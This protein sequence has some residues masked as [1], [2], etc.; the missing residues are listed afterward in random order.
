MSELNEDVVRAF[1]ALD[2]EGNVEEGPGARPGPRRRPY[3]SVGHPVPGGPPVPVH[4]MEPVRA[5]AVLLLT[6][7]GAYALPGSPVRR[8]VHDRAATATSEAPST[9]AAPSAAKMPEATGLRLS[10]VTGRCASFCATWREAPKSACASFRA[11][12]PP[13][14]PRPAAASRRPPAAWRPG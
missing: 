8:W 10:V 4:V 14:S 7:A 1:L 9:V 3:A 13:C 5:A 6:A 11:P 12:K 2:Y